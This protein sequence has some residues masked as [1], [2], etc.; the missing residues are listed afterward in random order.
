MPKLSSLPNPIDVTQPQIA[1]TRNRTAQLRCVGH[2]EPVCPALMDQIRR[3]DLEADIELQR[4]HHSAA[5]R[6][7]FRA[8]EL[9]GWA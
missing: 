3:L 1:A 5:E 6:L 8:A 2:P 9:R 4:G 7:A